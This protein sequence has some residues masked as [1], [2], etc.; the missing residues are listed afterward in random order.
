MTREMREIIRDHSRSPEITRDC[1]RG[2]SRNLPVA[3]LFERLVAEGA[4]T[5]Q[6]AS[7]II[8]QVRDAA[9]RWG[10]PRLSH[11]AGCSS[12]LVCPCCHLR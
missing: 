3:G 7:K 4:Y 6:I 1:A 12:H 2:P 5:E 9:E 11:P 10:T 8:K